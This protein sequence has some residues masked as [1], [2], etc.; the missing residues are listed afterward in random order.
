VRCKRTRPRGGGTLHKGS[1]ISISRVHMSN[2]KVCR[3]DSCWSVR[4][5]YVLE[6]LPDVNG[7]GLIEAGRDLTQREYY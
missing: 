1:T 5:D 2:D 3:K 6:K 4:T 7:P